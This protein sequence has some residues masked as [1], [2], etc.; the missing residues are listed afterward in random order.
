MANDTYQK[1]GYFSQIVPA[2][3]K[4]KEYDIKN[5]S[6]IRNKRKPDFLFIGDSIIQYWELNTYFGNPQTLLINRGIE[7]DN[8]TY[9]NKRFDVD[10]LQLQPEYCILGIGIND[11]LELEGDYWRGIPPAPYDRVL[12][13]AKQNILEVISKVR[14][15][16]VTLILSS[17]LPINIGLSLHQ[18]DRKRFICE[19]NQWLADISK[20]E[21]LICLNY[22]IATTYPGT[23]KLLDNITDDGLH[24]NGKG[25]EIMSNILKNTLQKH[26]IT[27]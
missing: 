26:N 16:P 22:Y 14:D 18:P 13:L 3:R 17:L 2:D 20:R 7:G 4:R 15:S 11:T 8:T 21:N 10:A 23:N 12:S 6:V 1:L 5:H 25:Y 24:P 19:F 27:I 9:L